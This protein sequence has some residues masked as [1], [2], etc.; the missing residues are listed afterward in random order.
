[1]EIDDKFPSSSQ[2]PSPVTATEGKSNDEVALT[3]AEA[4]MFE[5]LIMR[6]TD[7]TGVSLL[8]G[9]CTCRGTI[10][11]DPKS[12]TSAYKATTLAISTK[13][14]LLVLTANADLRAQLNATNREL[15]SKSVEVQ[16]LKVEMERM[17]PYVFEK[18]LRT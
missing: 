18:I 12:I 15:G 7:G 2:D 8:P 9:I 1:M 16:R 11:D 4:K 10:T 13:A 5:S 6:R 3:P 17:I 14:F